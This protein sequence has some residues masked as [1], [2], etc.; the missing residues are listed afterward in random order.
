MK[1][2]LAFIS[3]AFCMLYGISA[4]AARTSLTVSTNWYVATTGS[5]TTGDGSSGNPWATPQFAL[6][7]IR[8]NYDFMGFTPV[9]NIAD[10]TYNPPS[11]SNQVLSCTAA[12]VGTIYV[13]IIGNVTN[14]QNVIFN[15]PSGDYGISAGD[16]CWLVFNGIKFTG[17]ASGSGSI[18]VFAKNY[19]G[20]DFGDVIFGSNGSTGGIDIFAINQGTIIA[21]GNFTIAGNS[22]IIYGAQTGGQINGGG[23]TVTIPSAISFLQFAQ[24]TNGGFITGNPGFT[25]IGAGVA[26]STGTR[27][28][29]SVNAVIVVNGNTTAFPGN[30][31]YHSSTGGQIQ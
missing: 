14:P 11:G 4:E 15:V 3:L 5:D 1:K 26:G 7:T 31:A 22:Q 23:V 10:G 2:F 8:N 9:L 29:A 19:G 16:Y 30:A 18:F 17:P 24:S 6:N 21:T 20:I 25:Y 27:A 13:Q 12:N 28:D